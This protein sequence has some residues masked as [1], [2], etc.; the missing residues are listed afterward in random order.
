MYCLRGD[1]VSERLYYFSRL[2]AAT[3][4]ENDANLIRD[5]PRRFKTHPE[6]NS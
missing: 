2:G 5:L 3:R 6:R 4:R 1:L